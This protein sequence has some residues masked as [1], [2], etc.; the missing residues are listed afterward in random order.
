MTNPSMCKFPECGRKVRAN[1]L[2][3]AH[4]K[5]RTRGLPLKPLAFRP[6]RQ[7]TTEQRLLGASE[8]VASTGCRQWTRALTNKGYA[9]ITLDGKRQLAHRVVYA[10]HHG[11]IPADKVIDHTCGNRGCINIAHLRLVT[12]KQ[13]NENRTRLNST[14]TSGYRGVTYLPSVGKWFASVQHDW[15]IYRVGTFDTAEEAGEAARLKRLE[16]YTHNDRDRAA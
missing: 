14:N 7:M 1:S 5:Q 15:D 10:R 11:P 9:I 2:C 16:L 3:D 8:S 12:T 6:T 13:N 4:N